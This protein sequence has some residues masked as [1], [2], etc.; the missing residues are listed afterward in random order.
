MEILQDQSQLILNDYVRRVYPDQPARFGKLILM[1][2]HLRG[3]SCQA[4]ERLFF[5][6]TIGDIPIDRLI[7]DIYQGEKLI[8]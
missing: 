6:E 5:K 2:P 1:L 4:I 3:I 7:C 8:P